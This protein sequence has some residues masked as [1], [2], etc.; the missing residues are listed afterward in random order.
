VVTILFEKKYKLTEYLTHNIATFITKIFMV[1]DCKMIIQKP[2]VSI[3]GILDT[4][5]VEVNKIV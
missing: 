1:V 5:E 4:V 3:N 2:N